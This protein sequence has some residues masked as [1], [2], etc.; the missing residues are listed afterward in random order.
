[1]Q[2]DPPCFVERLRKATAAKATNISGLSFLMLEIYRHSRVQPATNLPHALS[3]EASS[4]KFALRRHS[5]VHHFTNRTISLISGKSLQTQNALIYVCSC[6]VKPCGI[7]KV[8]RTHSFKGDL[9]RK[10]VYV[11]RRRSGM[12][13]EPTALQRKQPRHVDTTAPKNCKPPPLVQVV[14]LPR[15]SKGT[16]EDTKIENNAKF[17]KIYEEK[18]PRKD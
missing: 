14:S 13:R 5:H 2:P 12:R 3:K 10:Y 1:M 17:S 9:T 15:R 8:E 16:R 6:I 18:D 4:S 7:F 11:C